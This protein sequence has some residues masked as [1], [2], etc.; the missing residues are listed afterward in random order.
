LPSLYEIDGETV[1]TGVYADGS[2]Q[3]FGLLQHGELQHQDG[4]RLINETLFFLDAEWV[5]TSEVIQHYSSP[6]SITVY[7]CWPETGDRLG[8]LFLELAPLEEEDQ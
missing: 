1:I 8:G 6:D 5:T 2:T 7:T 3:Q 4:S